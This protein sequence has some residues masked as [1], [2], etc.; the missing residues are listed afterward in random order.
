MRRIAVL[1]A[2]LA[3]LAVAGCGG[4]DKP[5]ASGASSGSSSSSSSSGSGAYAKSSSSTGGGGGA[6][7]KV[8]ADPSGAIKFTKSS[9]TAKAGKVTVDFSNK[10][11]VPHGVVIEGNGVK[12]STKVVTG[13]DAPAITVDLE[14]GTY[15]YYCPVG[16]HRDEGMEGKLT[17][18]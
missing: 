16:D 13:A 10:S 11:Q 15:T 8:A 2:L 14:P 17:V 7:L 9:L 6:A 12:E 3:A 18:R 1:A 5:A 4:S